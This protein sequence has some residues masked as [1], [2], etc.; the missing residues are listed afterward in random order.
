MIKSIAEEIEYLNQIR[1][2]KRFGQRVH[3]REI[4]VEGLGGNIPTISFDQLS[5]QLVTKL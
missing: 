4:Y 1:L 5:L 2:A 3:I